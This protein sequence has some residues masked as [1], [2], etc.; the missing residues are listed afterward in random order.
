[1][2]AHSS[3][4]LGDI[5]SLAL[6]QTGV[7][8]L[9]APKLRMEH[10]S[11]ILNEAANT[12]DDSLLSSDIGSLTQGLLTTLARPASSVAAR[13]APQSQLRQAVKQE[14]EGM[15]TSLGPGAGCCGNLVDL[16]S[17]PDFATGAFGGGMEGGPLD[18]SVLEDDINLDELLSGGDSMPPVSLATGGVTTSGIQGMNALLFPPTNGPS[19]LEN[20]TGLEDDDLSTLLSATGTDYLE[21]I[22]QDMVAKPMSNVPSPPYI[23]PVTPLS[24]TGNYSFVRQ[25]STGRTSTNSALKFDVNAVAQQLT[26]S[27]PTRPPF[28]RSNSVATPFMVSPSA[29]GTVLASRGS[30]MAAGGIPRGRIG[31][32]SM[33]ARVPM[34]PTGARYTQYHVIACTGISS[35]HSPHPPPQPTKTAPIN[36]P[37]KKQI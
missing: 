31:A 24:I 26:Q 6:Q 14:G 13:S 4:S 36:K 22:T 32:G 10:P 17:L 30:V 8:S 28:H 15:A 20:G 3:E 7:G 35:H 25:V 29:S 21:S 12:I 16:N 9:N 18:L 11:S 2:A 27:Y 23:P 1:M 33:Y 34:P 37:T 19:F 5:L